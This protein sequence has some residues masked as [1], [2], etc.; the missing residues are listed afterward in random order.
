MVLPSGLSRRAGRRL[1]VGPLDLLVPPDQILEQTG[2][3]ASRIVP[4]AQAA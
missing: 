4:L 2:V 3:L 1:V